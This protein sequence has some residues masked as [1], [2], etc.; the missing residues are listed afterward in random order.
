[1][2]APPA[3]ALGSEVGAR[4]APTGAE[5]GAHAAAL[6]RFRLLTVRNLGKERSAACAR[7]A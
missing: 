5:G 2:T 3:R 7:E 6:L 1:L 4:G